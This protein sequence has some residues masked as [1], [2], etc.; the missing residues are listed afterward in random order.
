MAGGE[1]AWGIQDWLGFTQRRA[2]LPHGRLAPA[3]M[4]RGRAVWGRA[5][6]HRQRLLASK[7]QT[8]SKAPDRTSFLC[9]NSLLA[10]HS[11]SVLRIR[12][13]SRHSDVG[14]WLLL[15]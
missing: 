1:G 11:R 13:A 9:Y 14:S 7:S 12:L 8:P 10:R 6:I 2:E 4:L 15:G 5:L 3:C